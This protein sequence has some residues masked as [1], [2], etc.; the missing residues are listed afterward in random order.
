MAERPR[1]RDYA[2]Q[3]TPKNIAPANW[4]TCPTGVYFRDGK[5][6]RETHAD[7]DG[8]EVSVSSMGRTVRVDHY[9]YKSKDSE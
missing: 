6:N 2:H 7:Y 8:A 3:K 5:Q 1:Y 4:A 9:H